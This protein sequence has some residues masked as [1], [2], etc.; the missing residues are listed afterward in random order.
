MVRDRE[1]RHARIVVF[2]A[3]ACILAPLGIPGSPRSKAHPQ[4]NP[5]PSPSAAADDLALILQRMKVDFASPKSTYP[6]DVRAFGS[7]PAQDWLSSL[8][9][10]GHWP[11]LKL[12]VRRPPTT[13]AYG[14][15]STP[16]FHSNAHLIR[17]AQM[18]S[19]YANPGTPD[20]HSPKMLEGIE[21]ALA[22]WYKNHTLSDNWWD[23]TVG[24]PQLLALTIVPLV[25]D[26]PPD[27]LHEGLS[28]FYIPQTK[29]PSYSKSA[30]SYPQQQLIR[31]VLARSDADVTEASTEMQRIISIRTAEG[32]QRDLSFH[33]HGPQ[34]YNAGYGLTL[35]I[36]ECNYATVL[37]GTR[38]AFSHDKLM[39]L[40]DFFLEGDGHMIRG[41]ALDY[42]S[43]GR[44]LLRK[45]GGEA[46][47]E[48]EPVCDQ[49]AALLPERAGELMALKKHIEGTGA[50]YS[51]LGNKYFWNS[52]F[53]THQREAYY[54]SVKMVSARTVGTETIHAENM[55]GRWLPF[56][57]TWILRRGDEYNRILPVLDWG[58]LPGVTSTH[59]VMPPIRNVSQPECFVG[60][61][62]DGTYGAASM[63]FTESEPTP[64]ISV[65]KIM[66]QGRK[67]W[68]LFDHEMVALGAGISSDR[69]A[70]VGTTLN[71]TGLHGPALIDGH[72]V[73][74]GE[75]KVSPSSWVLHDEVG[76]VLL[77]S[78]AARLKVGPQTSPPRPSFPGRPNTPITEQV[79][80]LWVDHGVRPK[81]AQYAY[82]VVPGVNAQELADWQ[83]H[84]PVRIVSN[85][86]EQQAVINE[87][88]SVAEI[89]FYKSGRAVLTPGLTVKVD[90][91][92]L[93]VL[94]K[95][96]NSTRIAVSS[97]G[98]EVLWV[99]LTLTTPKKEQSLTFDMPSGDMAGKSQVLDAPLRW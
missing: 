65:F 51:Y 34:L 82:A 53:M 99:H 6:H 61:V 2:M 40:T 25:D 58:R 7:P 45:G 39:L 55:N 64:L 90:R 41:K 30:L 87:H 11:D 78:T 12:A 75:S 43:F 47:V 14:D 31:G 20:Y 18:T 77:G 44:T 49:L 63:I 79:L 60:G 24:E 54:I 42:S 8:A 81:D 62:S 36:D 66:T 27:L 38:Y 69:D 88:A 10:D 57:T 72:D 70:P 92:C 52:D 9:A 89:V 5:V 93:A 33:Q 1:G 74:P 4:A 21:H 23:N 50:P 76:Y 91:P 16:S 84:P 59:E 17:L 48:L 95:H 96:G 83:A 22:Y 35:L 68:F 97:P 13:G 37:R 26:L 98:G 56:G 3:A 15:P 46:A 80:T 94:S 29:D 28:H 67:S 86:T 19:A 32:I 73:Q 85:T 71:Q